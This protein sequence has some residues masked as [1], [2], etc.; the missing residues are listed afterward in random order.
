M[1][2]RHGSSVIFRSPRRSDAMASTRILA[3][4]AVLVATATAV[5]L[6]GPLGA[7][8]APPAATRGADPL[9][10]AVAEAARTAQIAENP[11]PLV[12]ANRV[13][14]ELRA[15]ILAR[16]PAARAAAAADQ[17]QR[18]AATS[19]SSRVTTRAYDQAVVVNLGGTPVFVIFAADIDPLEGEELTAKAEAAAARLQLAFEEATE[20]RS[21][22][23][24]IRAGLIALA[25]TAL[26]GLALWLVIRIDLRIA[27]RLGGTAERR[28]LRLPGGEALVRVADAR[29]NVQ[30]L[31]ALISL[32]VGLLLT[33]TWLTAVLRR[34]PYTRPWGESL[35]GVLF[36]TVVS[37]GQRFVDALPDLLTV[38]VIVV[39]TRFLA[40][41]MRIAFVAV[42]EGRVTLPGVHPDTAQPTRRIV[43]ALLWLCALIVSYPYLPGSQ[44]EVFKGVSVFVGLLVS[45]GST[46]VM[47]QVMSGL[48]VTYSRALRCG[49]FVRVANIE[50]TVTAIGTLATK[51]KT[52]RNEEITIPNA[53]AVSNA[54]TNY[55]RNATE[56]VYVGTSVTIGY[57][58]P[59]RQVHALLRLAAERTAGVRTEPK[60]V[61]LQ[62]ALEDFYVQYTLFVALHQPERRV[63][64][65]DVLHAH[66]QDAFNEYGVQIMSPRY[67]ADPAGPKVVPPQRWY[68]APAAPEGDI[69][70]PALSTQTDSVRLR[71]V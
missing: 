28:L 15:T 39:L 8:Q 14:V 36:S 29:T 26:Y 11:A 63:F 53:V 56:G 58:T 7:Q 20:L 31:F 9:A 64:I 62:T 61:I 44:S 48:M 6:P 71:G 21:P 68:S 57:D 69:G 34:F 42:E 46:G 49:D 2:A 51:I 10:T 33:Y 55:S 17:I 1:T 19:P 40:K 67:I 59:W 70:Q 3:A 45:L 25:V 5:L 4:V 22:A 65:L 35:R 12:F 37:T 32:V 24:L 41:L 52:P 60:P 66:I 16:P 47:N 23:R 54:L 27:A 18:L 50:G 30:R 43:V 38:L 13:I